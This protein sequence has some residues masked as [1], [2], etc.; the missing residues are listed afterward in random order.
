MKSCINRAI[1]VMAFFGLWSIAALAASDL[2]QT[3]F[4]G[5]QLVP[6]K[7][8]EVLY[9]R[10]GA[11]LKPYKRVVILDCF[12]AF[13]K[14][15]QRDQNSSGLRVSSADMNRIKK[16][17]AEEFNKIFV[18]E[19]QNKGGYEVVD[20]GGEDVLILR[21][22]IIDLDISSPDTLNT[23]MGRSFATSAGAMTLYLEVLD[24]DTGEILARI[25]DAE[26]SRDN[27]RLMW[28]NSITNT[29]EADRLLRKW[30]VMMRGALDRARAASGAGQPAG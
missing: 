11:S 8:V 25:V 5:L 12:V 30:A 16:K 27:G 4:D 9:L 23:G 17:L 24:G 13:R 20:Q 28:Q 22:A 10:P 14:T 19:L 7:D 15:W 18:D 2:P 3:S 1:V 26:N 21:P 6:S 29:Q